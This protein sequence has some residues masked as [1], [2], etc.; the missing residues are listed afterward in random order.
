M[1]GKGTGVR[2]LAL[3]GPICAQRQDNGG[4]GQRSGN[5]D[6]GGMRDG[7]RNGR[8]CVTSTRL[9]KSDAIRQHLG[10]GYQVRQ[11]DAGESVPSI[12]KANRRRSKTPPSAH[13]MITDAAVLDIDPGTDL[14]SK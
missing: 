9:A 1:A 14:V 7:P 4:P 12:P 13:P 11:R 5:P 2:D 8:P 6:E 10:F 3:G